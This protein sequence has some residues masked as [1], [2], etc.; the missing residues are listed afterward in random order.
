MTTK[1]QKPSTDAGRARL[2]KLIH[3]ARRELERAGR[4][5]E[6]G[7]REMLRAAS[8]GHHDSTANMGYT[9]L[10]AALDH[11]KRA[12]FQVSR[13]ASAAPLAVAPMDSKVRAL[14]LFLHALGVVKDPSEKAL[15]AYVLRISKVDALQWAHGVRRD[16]PTARDRKELLIE[17]LKKWAMRFLPGAVK[18]L[19]EE[20][21]VLHRA[22]PLSG[23]DLERLQAAWNCLGQQ[24]GF[25]MH[26]A[27]WED[28]TKLLQRPIPAELAAL[29]PME[30][31]Q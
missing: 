17:T 18:R 20:V 24:R 29:K 12:G 31:Q 28:L 30:C 8:N 3:V 11:F 5:D 25:D 1:T 13:G 15:R 7:Y 6:P 23:P 26:W 27:A 2:I 21:A 19:C 22:T 14:W 16:L 10:K 9:D 4:L